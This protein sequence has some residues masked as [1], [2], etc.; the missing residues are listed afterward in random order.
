MYPR[1]QDTP[2]FLLLSTLV[3]VKSNWLLAISKD[4]RDFGIEPFMLFL[5]V[6]DESI[7]LCFQGVEKLYNIAKESN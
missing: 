2:F 4:T 1:K 3:A 7:M 5:Y 6:Q